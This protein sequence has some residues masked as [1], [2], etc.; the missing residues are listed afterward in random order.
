MGIVGFGRIG[1]AVAR[2]AKGFGMRVVYS[3]AV[4]LP[5][6]V[7]G[8][9]GAERLEL[10][11]LLAQADVVSIHTNLTP[12][13]RHLFGAETFRAMKPTA[14]IVNTSRG[15]VIDES[16]LADALETGEIFAAGLDVFEREPEVDAR[17]L[18]LDNV[19]VIP[20]LGSATV[21]TRNAMGDLVVD[22]VFAAI[23]GQR[24]P[25]LLNPD[26]LGG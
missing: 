4:Q 11:E 19:V 14:V 9:T 10:D 13:T 7:E 25:T 3:D 12:E 20:H 15:P 5:P 1:Q 8:E 2:R 23:D 18:Q 24:P 17:L 16:A 26:A 22:N 21:D 6:E